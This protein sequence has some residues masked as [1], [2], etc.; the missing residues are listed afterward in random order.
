M[1]NNFRA[2]N[3]SNKTMWYSGNSHKEYLIFSSAGGIP[4][5]EVVYESSKRVVI[6]CDKNGILMNSTG[7]K[8]KYNFDIYEGSIIKKLKKSAI[9]SRFS[10]NLFKV[11]W[12]TLTS[13][14]TLI[15]I[16]AGK[17]KYFDDSYYNSNFNFNS[18]EVEVVGNIYEN[19]ELLEI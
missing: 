1:T 9:D 15:C 18:N 12:C 4:Y 17:L 6:V 10:K 19:T 11:E 14:F 7:I 8:D 3:Y 2:W 5:W 13:S 16:N